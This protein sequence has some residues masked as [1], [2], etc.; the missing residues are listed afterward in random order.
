MKRLFYAGSSVMIADIACTALIRY[1]RDLAL[2]KTADVVS[3]PVIGGRGS[4]GY[5]HIPLGPASD[6]L[7]TVVPDNQG[8]TVDPNVISELERLTRELAP[9]FP[10]RLLLEDDA[11]DAPHE[12]D[13]G[14]DR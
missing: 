3:M 13:E 14:F 12:W 2:A 10:V 9:H 1:A 8:E 4:Y 6:L 5:V 11:S 7:N